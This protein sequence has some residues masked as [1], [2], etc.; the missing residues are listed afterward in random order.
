M[1]GATPTPPFNM[2]TANPERLAVSNLPLPIDPTRFYP[3]LK[4]PPNILT[5]STPIVHLVD[6]RPLAVA[7]F[8]PF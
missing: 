3:A 2:T 4:T 8:R 1:K 6:T 5:P 7:Y